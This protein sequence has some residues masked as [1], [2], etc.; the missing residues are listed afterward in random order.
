MTGGYLANVHIL[1]VEDNTFARRMMMEILK[2][3]GAM[4]IACAKDGGKPGKR[5]PRTCLT[6]FCSI[7]TC[8]R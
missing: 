6:W 7:G 3:L 2:Y 5:S 1:V 4:G 8:S